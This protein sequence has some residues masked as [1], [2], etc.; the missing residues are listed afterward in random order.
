MNN[1]ENWQ[2]RVNLAEAPPTHVCVSVLIC[3]Q[4]GGYYVYIPSLP[5]CLSQG[6]TVEEA[7]ANIKE[8]FEG[9]I[10]GY[11]ADGVEIPWQVLPPVH[12]EGAFETRIFI[13][14]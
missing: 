14:I 3:P 1:Y 7:A 2:Q 13:I 6:D 5:G 9:V 10:K 12:L 11:L 4:E 8:A